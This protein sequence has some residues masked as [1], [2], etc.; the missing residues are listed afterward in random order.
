MPTS[1]IIDKKIIKSQE[2]FIDT[3]INIA[4]A[5]TIGINKSGRFSLGKSQN[6]KSVNEL[7]NIP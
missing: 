7:D 1:I 3:W 4:K 2:D 5:I 6:A